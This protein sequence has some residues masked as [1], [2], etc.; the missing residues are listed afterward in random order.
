MALDIEN[1]NEVYLPKELNQKDLPHSFRYYNG[2]ML[3]L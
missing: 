1:V 2:V 3:S